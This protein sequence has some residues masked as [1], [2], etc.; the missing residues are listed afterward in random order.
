ML[1]PTASCSGPAALGPASPGPASPGPASPGPAS[2]GTASPGPREGVVCGFGSGSDS[3]ARG[4]V[5]FESSEDGLH[6]AFYFALGLGVSHIHDAIVVVERWHIV[7]FA[8]GI[9][10]FFHQGA[11]FAV[12][13][14]GNIR[15]ILRL[16]VSK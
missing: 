10:V 5:R 14:G 16:C 4:R 12:R 1:G 6:I 8:V 15:N 13:V 11:G 9:Q 2:L 3:S 7:V